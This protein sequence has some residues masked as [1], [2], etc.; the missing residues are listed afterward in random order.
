M[1][2]EYLIAYC[3]TYCGSCARCQGSV[4]FREAIPL[5]A[6]LVDS[7]GFQH[8]MPVQSKNST[9]P[10]SGRLW[11][12]LGERIHGLSVKAAEQAVAN[13]HSVSESA[14][15]NIRWTCALSVKN[16]PVTK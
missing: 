16:S 14:A 15:R 2:Q 12:S 10:S 4:F 7:H 8:W 6:E 1:K 5:V 13:H 11:T 3:G 9:T